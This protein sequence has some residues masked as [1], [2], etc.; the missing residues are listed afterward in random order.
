M[1]KTSNK[2]TLRAVS[3]HKRG[4][5]E[6]FHDIGAAWPTKSG[7]FTIRLN[8]LPLGDTILLVPPK[9]DSSNSDSEDA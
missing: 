6:S 8:A 5:K 1:S 7:G 2:P 9:G 3:I 4:D